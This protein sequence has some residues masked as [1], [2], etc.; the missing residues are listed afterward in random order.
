MPKSLVVNLSILPGVPNKIEGIALVRPDVLAVI[1]DN[2]FGLVDNATFTPG[3][4]VSSNDTLVRSRLLYIH[5]ASP[6]N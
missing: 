2:D 1:N 3:A 6:V 4:G 5:L